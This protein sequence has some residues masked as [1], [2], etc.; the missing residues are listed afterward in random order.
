M[1]RRSTSVV[2]SYSQMFQV[3]CSLSMAPGIS[4]MR[5]ENTIF[6]PS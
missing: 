3:G 4:G 6:V 2:R 1:T 5:I